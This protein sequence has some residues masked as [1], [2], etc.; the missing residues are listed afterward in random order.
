M[1]TDVHATV[2]L[3]PASAQPACMSERRLTPWLVGVCLLAVLALPCQVLADVVWVALSRQEPAYLEAAHVLRAAL[4]Q[5]DV[6]VGEWHDFNFKSAPPDLLVTVGSE[7]LVQLQAAADKTPIVALLV[8]R[9]TLDKL[10]DTAPGRITGV[11]F[12]QPMANQAR[13]L[14]AAFPNRSRVGAILGPS[15]AR[16][17]AD[18]AQALRRVGMESVFEVIQDKRELSEAAKKVLDNAEIFLALPDEEAVNNQTARFILL[19]SYRRGIP[20]MGYSAAFVKAGAAVGLVSSPKHLGEEAAR[21]VQEALSA[22][23]LPPPR[24]PM[25]FDVLVNPSVSRSLGLN[26]DASLLEKRV[27]GEEAPR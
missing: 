13:L 8:S 25:D 9:A 22:K 14:R 19:S 1:D 2:G 6:R 17:R 15:S 24:A 7:A 5:E 3:A 21:M 23:R 12:E 11:Y 20:V 16:Y 26:L 27:R 18:L 10:R 4:P